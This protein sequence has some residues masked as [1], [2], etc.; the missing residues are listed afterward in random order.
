MF[1]GG[2]RMRG[3]MSSSVVIVRPMESDQ[4]RVM[5]DDGRR[6]QSSVLLIDS[7]SFLAFNAGH[8]STA[9]NVHCPPIVRRRCGFRIPLENILR[10]PDSRERLMTGK[11]SVIVLYD[12]STESTDGVS[13]DVAPEKERRLEQRSGILSEDSQKSDL[14][15]VLESLCNLLPRYL[16]KNIFYLN[17]KEVHYHTTLETKY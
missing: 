10:C 12:D 17:G 9:H 5:L 1:D 11:Y 15:L 14:R 7:R 13:V 8:I 16:V 6:S 4:L 2:E 3:K